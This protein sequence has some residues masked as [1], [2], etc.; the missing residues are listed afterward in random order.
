MGENSSRVQ[1]PLSL[2][3]FAGMVELVDTTDLKSVA[4]YGVPVR[5]RLSAPLYEYFGL[6]AELVDALDLGSSA[7]KRES[8]SLSRPTTLELEWRLFI[9]I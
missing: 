3:H 1:I 7:F 2:R 4:I 9:N 6:M 8:S 5:L